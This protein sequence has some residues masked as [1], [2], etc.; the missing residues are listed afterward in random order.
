MSGI[1][2]YGSYIP[3]YRIKVEEIA[4]AWKKDPKEVL[5][6][7]KLT[8][9][10]VPSADEDTVTMG[11]EAGARALSAAG[12]KAHQLG[13]VYVG[14][15]SHPYVVNP[16]S[17]TI[18]EFLGVGELYSAADFE[19]ACKAATAALQLTSSFA[20]AKKI[21]Y[22]MIIGSDTAQAKPHDALEFSAAAAASAFI[23]GNK[24]SEILAKIVDTLSF[25]S[26]TPDFWRRE[27]MKFPAHA[28]RFTG[29]RAYFAHVLGAAQKLFSKSKTNAKNYDYCV[30]H[31]PNGKFPRVV[32]RELGFTDQQ[33][34]PSL[35]VDQIGNPYSA[36]SLLG[37]AAVL[38][39]AKPGDKIFF[40]SYGSGAGSDAFIFETTNNITARQ[41]KITPVSSF[42]ENCEY[43]SYLDFLKETYLHL[44]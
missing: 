27:A 35:I 14:S 3:R 33:L 32:A 19:F 9:K 12:L 11:V 42:Y 43:I 10:S 15:E 5:S 41:K 37:L 6:G 24:P 4:I 36:S 17:T 44:L 28:G 30:F 8:Q 39:I 7:L 29:E 21:D 18:A 31:M 20:D 40:V 25:S 38:D 16:S 26:D 1:V 13:A 2:S 22:G 34:A 23:I